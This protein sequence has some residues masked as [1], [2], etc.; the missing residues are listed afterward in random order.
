MLC[1]QHKK[2]NYRHLSRGRTHHWSKGRE[3][4]YDDG[5]YLL[6][7]PN[8]IKAHKHTKT[9]F[10]HR[11]V[12]EKHIGRYLEDDEV[13]HHINGIKTDN[14]IENLQLM[15]RSEHIRHHSKNRVYKRKQSLFWRTRWNWLFYG[16]SLGKNQFDKFV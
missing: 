8:H 13:V 11:Y 9:V 3:K 6:I 14:R 7:L 2:N 16:R 4:Y 1:D 15:K 5:Y 12:M 10:E